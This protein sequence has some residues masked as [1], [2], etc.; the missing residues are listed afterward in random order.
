MKYIL[1]TDLQIGHYLYRIDKREKRIY[2]DCSSCNGLGTIKVEY[3]FGKCEIECPE[4]RDIKNGSYGTDFIDITIYEVR[5]ERIVGFICLGRNSFDF[6]VLL[7]NEDKI[8]IDS[9]YISKNG[10]VT[11]QYYK[12][13]QEAETLCKEFNAIEIDKKKKFLKEH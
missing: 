11:K 4:C 5:S 9:L 10:F 2:R 3:K 7:S 6:D 1:E 12:T 8:D 13:E